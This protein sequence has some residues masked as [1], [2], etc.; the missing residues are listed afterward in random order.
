MF[1]SHAVK[2]K[3]VLQCFPRVA[4]KEWHVL[5]W[6]LSGCSSNMACNIFSR[7]A[8][9]VYHVLQCFFFLAMYLKCGI[10]CNDFRVVVIEWYVLQCIF[11]CCSSNVACSAMFYFSC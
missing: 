5:N 6:L 7:V 2:M 9:K 8:G 1:L 11:L 10:F 4:V 3:H